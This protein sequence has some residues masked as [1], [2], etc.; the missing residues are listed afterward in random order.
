MRA[1]TFI[2]LIIGLGV[3][4]FA[5]YSLLSAFESSQKNAAKPVEHVPV[6][7]AK[8]TI[9]YA[10]TITDEMVGEIRLVAP[11]PL[12]S[13]IHDKAEAVGRVSAVRIVPGTPLLTGM[14]AP[15]GTPPGAQHQIPRG[16]RAVSVQVASHTVQY[17]EPGDR[18]DVLYAA[19]DRR[20]SAP[21]VP[22]PILDNVEVFSVGDRRPGMS[23][24]GSETSGKAKGKGKGK[25]K[26]KER[27][28]VRS[29]P[30]LR[31][32]G[33]LTAV[34]LLLRPDKAQVLSMADLNGDIRLLPRAYGDDTPLE[35]VDLGFLDPAD[36]EDETI[37]EPVTPAA[38]EPPQPEFDVVQVFQGGKETKA[39][40][41]KE[42]APAEA[43]SATNETKPSPPQASRNKPADSGAL[44]QWAR[45]QRGRNQ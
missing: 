36:A 8:T 9:P 38:P 13:S 11:S 22:R 3:A 12:K 10:A 27:G 34:K 2:P 43:P 6:V 7:I 21:R 32:S 4:V 5:V 42:A 25:G 40:F 41:R 37:S 29:V 24:P 23:M 26:G 31:S 17:L 30:S 18:V 44:E 45:A 20:A 14:L 33:G 28:R 39:E 35:G 15:K 16:Y 19:T 1:S